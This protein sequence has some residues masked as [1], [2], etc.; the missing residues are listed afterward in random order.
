VGNFTARPGSAT[1]CASLWQAANGNFYG[2]TANDGNF[3]GPGDGT[4]FELTLAGAFSTLYTF[5]G[6]DGANPQDGLLP[7]NGGFYGTTAEGGANAV[8]T[9]FQFA[10]D[11]TLTTLYSFGSSSGCPDGCYPYAPL[12]LASNGRFYGTATVGGVSGGDGTVFEITPT[13]TLTK[14]HSFRA[15]DGQ[16]YGGLIQG[17]DGAFYGTATNGTNGAV[18][19][20][21]M[22]GL[23][24]F[25]KPVPVSGAVG[26]EVTILG[27]NLTG[28]TNVTF[29]GVAAAFTVVS[30][31]AITAAVPA[32][33][34]TG[35]IRVA[36]PGGV[37]SNVGAFVVTH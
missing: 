20:R 18:F 28:T 30:A 31:S 17:T 22:A 11:G 16:P 34:G 15:T 23:P 10:P 36:T 3:G 12:V 9:V 14:M 21:L 13:G 1:L 24:P 35:K 5:T 37:L 8:G 25:I 19:Y 29:N 33:A 26:S 6:K 7:T 27:T 4:I 2:T 32:G